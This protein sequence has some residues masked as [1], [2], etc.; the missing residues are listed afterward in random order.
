MGDYKPPFHMTDVAQSSAREM[1]R[2]FLLAANRRA[3]TV[4]TKGIL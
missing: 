2:A 4:Q 3:D 1:E